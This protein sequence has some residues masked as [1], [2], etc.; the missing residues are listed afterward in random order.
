M[1]KHKA[2]L[3]DS[4]CFRSLDSR[5]HLLDSHL[6]LTTSALQLLEKPQVQR[7]DRK[8]SFKKREQKP[9]F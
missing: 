7:L 6:A 3:P 5:N 4:I 1:H 8:L 9:Q 2:L